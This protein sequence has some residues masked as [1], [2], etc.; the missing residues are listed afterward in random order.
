MTEKKR[1]A[2]EQASIWNRN[3]QIL[4][5]GG[6]G[7]PEKP[8]TLLRYWKEQEKAGYPGAS[9]NVRYFAE[10]LQEVDKP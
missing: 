10:L 8:Q 2:K 6:Y 9:E 1:S 7:P 3:L 4:G 5:D